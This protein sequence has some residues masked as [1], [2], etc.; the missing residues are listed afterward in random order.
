VARS[1]GGGIEV[2]GGGTLQG[3]R[4]RGQQWQR[5]SVYGLRK[6][7]TVARSEVEVEAATC[8]KARD[9]AVVCLGPTLRM[10]GGGSM[11]V[12]RATDERERAWGQKLA[13]W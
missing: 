7:T 3:R 11:T 8:S 4:G 6:R 5:D 2:N 10:I 12:S 13:V 9:E 1:E